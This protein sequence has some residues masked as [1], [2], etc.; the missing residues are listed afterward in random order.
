MKRIWLKSALS[1]LALTIISAAAG[2]AADL[3]NTARTPETV[4]LH[5]IVGYLAGPECNGRR[6]GEPGAEKAA[7]YLEGQ[8]KTIGVQPLPGLKGYRQEFPVTRGIKP[9][10]A[11]GAALN[12]VGWHFGEDFILAPFAGSGTVYDAPVVFAGYGISA[13]ELNW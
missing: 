5:E 7:E 6:T 1:L 3:A 4:W 10:G 9:V 13:P 8:L 11:P 2:P 12:A